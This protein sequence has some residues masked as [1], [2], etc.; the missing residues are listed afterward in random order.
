[1]THVSE[2]TR[3]AYLRWM[4]ASAPAFLAPF[5]LIALSQ[6][7]AAGGR[8]ATAAPAGL[9]SALIALAVGSVLFGRSYVRR[10]PLAPSGASADAAL[11]FVRSTSWSLLGFAVAPSILGLALVFFT[12]SL[13]DALLMLALTLGGFALL[14]PRATQWDSWLGHLTAPVQE[15]PAS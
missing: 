13:G 12:R 6:V 1:M 9:R 2:N 7:L 8:A 4:R 14:Y 3:D 15:G 5:A 10:V 11:A